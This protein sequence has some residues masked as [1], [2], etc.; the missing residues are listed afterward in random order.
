MSFEDWADVSH[1][2]K[3]WSFGENSK[4]KVGKQ[5]GLFAVML[6][7]ALLRFKVSSAFDN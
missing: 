7:V 5:L 2:N 1:D 4:C 3:L 6:K